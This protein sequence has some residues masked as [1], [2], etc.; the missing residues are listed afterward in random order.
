M[1]L[2]ISIGKWFAGVVL[3]CAFAAANAASVA[4]V[5]YT[6][7][8]IA[9]GEQADN[10]SNAYNETFSLPG[11]VTITKFSFWGYYSLGSDLSTDNFLANGAQLTG[12]SLFSRSS[13]GTVN[14]LDL[15]GGVVGETN[16][17]RYDLDL[18]GLNAVDYAGGLPAISLINDSLD[19]EWFWQGTD[20]PS[21]ARAFLLEGSR[22]QAV[23]E[24]GS[25][26]LVGLALAALGFL[27]SR[28]RAP[29]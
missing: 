20:N 17:Y 15:N 7:S 28:A 8:T 25:L 21:G 26:A 19:L 11:P 3:G 18:S 16:L 10:S 4:L 9:L 23:P 24:P 13:A 6:P 5:D 12:S 14:L 22:N 1:K 27:R 2:K 29:R